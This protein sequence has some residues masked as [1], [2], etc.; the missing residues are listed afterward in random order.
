MPDVRCFECVTDLFKI[1]MRFLLS[2]VLRN[3]RNTVNGG[4]H[5]LLKE[6]KSS[7][8]EDS[9]P[10]IFSALDFARLSCIGDTTVFFTGGTDE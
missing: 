2:P 1:L 8:G 7:F 5:D 4:F 3:L 9:F 10:S 6:S